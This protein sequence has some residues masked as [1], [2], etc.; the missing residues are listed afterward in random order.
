MP[1]YFRR[2]KLEKALVSLFLLSLTLSALANLSTV[3]AQQ[4][5]ENLDQASADNFV[6]LDYLASHLAE[7]ENH[8]VTTNGTVRTD[9]ASIYMFEDFWLQAQ[10][11]AKIMVVTRF[12]GLSVPSNGSI[13]EVSGVIQHSI[14]EGGFY[15][16]NA[17]SWKPETLP[18]FPNSVLPLMVLFVCSAFLLYVF[19]S[20]S[21]SRFSN[22]LKRYN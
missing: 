2:P 15:F 1:S 9:G 6:D 8:I 14:L 3:T 12:S 21:N 22:C 7:F 18:E 13:I 17:T 10:S 16:L 5:G 20:K 4:V 11:G 19:S